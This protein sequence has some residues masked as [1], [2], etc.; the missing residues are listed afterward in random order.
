MLVEPLLVLDVLGDLL[1]DVAG[2]PRV[3]V[4]AHGLGVPVDVLH[5]LGGDVDLA[6]NAGE[7]LLAPLPV[8]GGDDAT[9]GRATTAPAAGPGDLVVVGLAVG[10]ALVL[11]EGAAA[12]GLLALGANEV[13]EKKKKED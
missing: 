10:L 5:A 11:V 3:A 7:V 13:L 8:D 9:G 1:A 6:P 4:L 2:D 12:K